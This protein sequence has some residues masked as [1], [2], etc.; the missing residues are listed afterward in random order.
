MHLNPEVRNEDGTRHLQRADIETVRQTDGWMDGWDG[1]MDGCSLK[2]LFR[3]CT[4]P[5]GPFFFEKKHFL[6]KC[7]LQKIP[8]SLFMN[9]YYFALKTIPGDPE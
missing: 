6:K 5:Q 2:F 4:C 3:G 7:I 8:K 1:W 9:K